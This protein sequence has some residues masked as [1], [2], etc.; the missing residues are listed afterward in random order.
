MLTQ[1]HRAQCTLLTSQNWWQIQQGRPCFLLRFA[2]WPKKFC[3]L[4]CA[5]PCHIAYTFI[6]LRI[7]S[8]YIWYTFLHFCALNRI[9]LRTLHAQDSVC[10]MFIINGFYCHWKPFFPVVLNCLTFSALLAKSTI[11][12]PNVERAKT[13]S[14]VAI[15]SLCSFCPRF[16]YLTSTLY[17]TGCLTQ[18]IW[19]Y[20]T[21]RP[22]K[23]R[24]KPIISPTGDATLRPVL[25]SLSS[26]YH[27]LRFPPSQNQKC[28][29]TG[30]GSHL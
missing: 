24:T 11:A 4:F 30:H 20:L 16:F 23:L 15:I 29:L 22:W 6:L 9:I 19:A 21:S 17:P 3:K 2:G 25:S 27:Q 12:F 1:F 26:C 18:T 10:M 28:T 7:E 5:E 14:T 13:P 8:C